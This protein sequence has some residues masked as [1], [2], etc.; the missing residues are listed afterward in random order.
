MVHSMYPLSPVSYLQALS[1][2]LRYLKTSCCLY[3]PNYVK[4]FKFWL[5]AELL[6]YLSLWIM[7][8]VTALEFE[9]PIAHVDIHNS[10][11]FL[12]ITL[13][14]HRFLVYSVC[15]WMLKIKAWMPEILLRIS[16]GVR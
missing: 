9:T 10:I 4:I 13:K 5:S 1:K 14:M 7:S 11:S 2:S 12:D 3:M 6:D 16:N 15:S 8:L